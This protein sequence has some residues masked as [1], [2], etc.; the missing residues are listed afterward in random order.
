MAP[1][2]RTASVHPAAPSGLSGSGRPAGGDAVAEARRILAAGDLCDAAAALE[3]ALAADP[4]PGEA[5]A[6]RRERERLRR[7]RRDYPHDRTS[8]AKL[9]REAVRGF[10]EEEIAE[11]E[12]KGLLDRILVDGQPRWFGSSISNLWHRSREV[13]PRWLIE[14]PTHRRLAFIRDH[15]AEIASAVAAGGR[16]YVVPRRFEVTMTVTVKADAVP[17]GKTVRCWLP[18]PVE[19]GAQRDIALASADP[20][21]VSVDRPDAPQRSVHLERPA[22]AGEPTRFRIAYALT[23][24]ATANVV[25]PARVKPLPADHPEVRAWCR[26]QPPHVVFTPELRKLAS[27]LRGG[28]ENPAVLARRIFDWVG[29]NILYSYAPEYST[30]PSL[31]PE[32]LRRGSGD[33]GQEAML[34]IALCRI[35]GIPAR[36]QTAWTLWPWKPGMHDWTEIFLDAHG[37]VPVDPYESVGYRSVCEEGTPEERERFR[38]FYCGGL[39]GWRLVCNRDHG[40]PLSPPKTHPRSDDVDF[41]RGEVEWE[42]G[43][44]YF[45]SF[46][47]E[48]KAKEIPS[49]K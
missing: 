9:L 41:Q 3:Q 22:A 39:D 27:E 32:C 12:A 7:I 20:E 43:N 1:P 37:W 13:R 6:I 31:A 26:E 34:F 48:L 38:S 45:D 21:P 49:V 35:N 47:Y 36:W 11:W 18:Y 42:G 44:L 28:E 4:S 2:A 19:Y 25:D 33:C 30:I 46:E 10:R 24:Y 23:R 29:T 15:Q 40:A 14:A 16:P 17:A 5:Q 8:L